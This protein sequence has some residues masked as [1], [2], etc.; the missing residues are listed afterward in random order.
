LVPFTV[1]VSTKSIITQKD[2]EETI[3]SYIDGDDVFNEDFLDGLYITSTSGVSAV[4]DASS[5]SYIATMNIS[6][7][8]L[9]TSFSKHSKNITGSF[10]IT[11]V[12]SAGS[13]VLQ[14]VHT[15]HR[16]ILYQSRSQPFTDYILIH[17][18]TFYSEPTN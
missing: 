17:I 4:M 2:L 7:L 3:N 16:L 5:L 14:Q 8:F 1:I 11:Y 18:E 12:E 9:D 10:V 13:T 15:Q 6:K